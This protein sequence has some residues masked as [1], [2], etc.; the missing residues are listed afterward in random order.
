MISQRIEVA[1]HCPVKSQNWFAEQVQQQIQN[2]YE[3]EQIIV[4]RT[5]NEYLEAETTKVAG[6]H[7]FVTACKTDQ[8]IAFKESKGAEIIDF[9]AKERQYKDPLF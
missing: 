3:L 5:R 6:W 4:D 1:R 9:P 8:L 2:D 7:L